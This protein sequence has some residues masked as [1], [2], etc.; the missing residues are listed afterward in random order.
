MLEKFLYNDFFYHLSR[1]L[2]PF[3]RLR[4]KTREHI[5]YKIDHPK[6][7]LYLSEKYIKPYLRAE[8]ENFSFEAKKEF[9][10]EKIIWLFWFQGKNN[11]PDLVKS[12]IK[13]VK[14][15]MSDYKIIILDK[16]NMKEYIDF[17]SFVY[18]RLEKKFFGQKSMAFFSDLLRLTL[19]KTYGGIWMD[20]TLFLSDKIPS[21]LLEKDFFVFERAQRV[22]ANELEKVLHSRYFA[23]SYFNYNDDF[24]VKMFSSFIIS[25]KNHPFTNAMLDILMAYWKN[26]EAKNHH[27]FALHFIFELLKKE[28]FK[29][30]SFY[31]SD[32]E[33]HLL[34]FYSQD[35]YDERLW[36]EIKQK[37]FLHKL[38]Y[39]KDIKEN[40]MISK[41][42]KQ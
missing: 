26:D 23:Y 33:I 3:K 14:K 28:G 24:M 29:N 7:S 41:I 38:T 1:L 31:I 12:C 18:D 20:A 32:F 11:A 8:L 22:S 10:D 35:E 27:Y 25:T 39:F 2:I 5:R 17:P 30:D 40:S 37:S 19:L 6:I 21:V 9:K 16:D 42:L 15:H 4:K 13:S 34:Q 36:Q